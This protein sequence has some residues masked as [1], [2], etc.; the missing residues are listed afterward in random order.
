MIR[1]FLTGHSI[2]DVTKHYW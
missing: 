2:A 1:T